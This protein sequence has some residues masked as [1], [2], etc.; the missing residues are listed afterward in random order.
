MRLAREVMRSTSCH[1]ND[2]D[3]D[4]DG[5]IDERAWCGRHDRLPTESLSPRS[6]LRGG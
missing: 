6:D 1:E 5:A 2:H 3:V 4:N